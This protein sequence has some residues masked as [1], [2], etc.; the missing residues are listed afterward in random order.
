MNSQLETR[1][2]RALLSASVG[3]VAALAAGALVRPLAAQA[4]N[5]DAI[6][7][8]GSFIGTSTTLIENYHT[9]ADVLQG[10]SASTGTGVGGSSASGTGV[11]GSS[12]S[13]FGVSGS[14][15]TSIGVD[16]RSSSGPGV[17][18]GSV[19]G[20]GVTGSSNSGNGV[21]GGSNSGIGVFGSTFSATLPAMAAGSLGGN[22]GVV[23]FSGIFLP[24]TPAKTGVH[25]Y[26]DQDSTARGVFGQSYAGT[27]VFG[28]SGPYPVPSS[29]AN[30]GVF[31]RSDAAGSRGVYG[32]SGSGIGTAGFTGSGTA[33]SGVALGSAGYALK[34]A[35]RVRL[36]QSAG[37]AT[38]P[39]GSNRVTVTPGIDLTSASV[40][41]ATLNG[42]VAAAIAVRNVMIDTAADT[43]SIALTEKVGD[44]VSVAWLVLG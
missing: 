10:S 29:P 17:T 18:G 14:S 1:S 44:P 35:G 27:G 39:A 42:R 9:G 30:I 26:A 33:L 4:A 24:T 21:D 11:R 32:Y 41:L 6:K 38:V 7:V 16:G 34:T 23:G 40:V 36:D 19:S 5:G 22:T 20:N 2:R 37:R 15:A 31:G 13:G 25:G 28:Y 43:F 3:G 8:G 12:T